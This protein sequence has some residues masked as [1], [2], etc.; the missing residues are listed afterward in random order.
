MRQ[1][2]RGVRPLSVAAS[3]RRLA[4]YGGTLGGG[5]PPW[6]DGGTS[7]GARA[8]Y[9]GS[10]SYPPPPAEPIGGSCDL[11]P[12]NPLPQ[13]VSGRPVHTPTVRAVPSY[14]MGMRSVR[15]S[16]PR[17]AHE[18]PVNAKRC[19]APPPCRVSRISAQR[20]MAPYPAYAAHM[21]Q[22]FAAGG[23]QKVCTYPQCVHRHAHI[24][25]YCERGEHNEILTTARRVCVHVHYVYV[26]R[27]WCTTCLHCG[28]AQLAGRR[29]GV[30][31]PIRE[32]MTARTKCARTCSTR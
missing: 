13:A 6:S 24:A 14:F 22:L 23:Q 11:Q 8:S 18:V 5:A 3:A 21:A 20:C 4:A 12:W 26:V 9:M 30:V 19:A 16:V 7:A 29:Q 31:R 17:Y 28:P 10:V 27:I 32:Y 15:A 1:P 2:A 25:S